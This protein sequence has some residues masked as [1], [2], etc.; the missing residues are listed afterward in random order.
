MINRLSPGYYS[1]M[2]LKSTT[3]RGTGE[4]WTPQASMCWSLKRITVTSTE[5]VK[6]GVP[7]N[8]TTTTNDYKKVLENLQDPCGS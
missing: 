5:S 3:H 6:H 1:C 8:T 4:I 2:F 7:N